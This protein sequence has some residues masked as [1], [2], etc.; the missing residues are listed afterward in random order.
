MK[1]WARNTLARTYKI[2]PCWLEVVRLMPLSTKR[3]SMRKTRINTPFGCHAV[4]RIPPSTLGL[5]PRKKA[6][7]TASVRICVGI[8]SIPL[9][10]RLPMGCP[11]SRT[12]LALHYYG[13]SWRAC[14][15]TRSVHE[16]RA[17]ARTR[18]LKNWDPRSKN[19]GSSSDKTRRH[20]RNSRKAKSLLRSTEGCAL[21]CQRIVTHPKQ[22]LLRSLKLEN[23]RSCAN[24]F[25]ERNGFSWWDWTYLLCRVSILRSILCRNLQS[26]WH[27]RGHLYTFTLLVM[28]QALLHPAL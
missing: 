17:W 19:F 15:E 1:R 2:S 5:S 9:W 21:P 20:S 26:L 12:R 22:A 27:Y 7:F 25:E 23:T 18:P 24:P 3:R 8:Y 10:D 16:S 14:A 13:R 28:L 6:T 11:L 4:G